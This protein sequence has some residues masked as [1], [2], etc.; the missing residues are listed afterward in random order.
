MLF[1]TSILEYEEIDRWNHVYPAV[2]EITA[3]KEA[4]EKPLG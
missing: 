4:L 3:F 1:N 2:K